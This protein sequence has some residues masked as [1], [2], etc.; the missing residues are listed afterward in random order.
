[1][2]MRKIKGYKKK[3]IIISHIYTYMYIQYV[4]FV[5]LEQN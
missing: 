3:A 5:E 4:M 1:M 2:G